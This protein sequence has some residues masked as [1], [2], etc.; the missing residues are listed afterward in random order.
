MIETNLEGWYP[1]ALERDIVPLR[2]ARSKIGNKPLVLWRDDEDQIHV[3]IDR[4]PHRSVRLSA[5]RN[6]GAYLEGV[7]HGWRFG[8]DGRVMAVPAEGYSA[9]PDIC[10]EVVAVSV[11]NGLVLANPSKQKALDA[12]KVDVKK[13][14]ILIRPMPIGAKQDIVCGSL[15]NWQG[16]RSIVTP[17]GEESCWVY[18]LMTPNSKEPASNGLR[19]INGRLNDLRKS[20]ESSS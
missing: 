16:L 6:F 19:R 13:N 10:V 18:G 7:Y 11:Q 2:L 3:W 20:L 5:G 4:C 9:K 14:E 12:P 1:V 8:K 17:T 15:S